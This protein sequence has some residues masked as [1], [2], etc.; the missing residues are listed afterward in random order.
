MGRRSP[1]PLRIKPGTLS[2]CG[3]EALADPEERCSG[4]IGV[5]AAIAGI[6]DDAGE[7]GADLRFYGGG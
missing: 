4:T 5:A 2:A 3:G 6:A 1:L 7:T